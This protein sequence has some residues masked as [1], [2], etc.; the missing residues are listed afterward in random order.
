MKGPPSP[1]TCAMRAPRA[2]TR[3]RCWTLVV[4]GAICLAQLG[5]GFKRK[6]PKVWKLPCKNVAFERRVSEIL[7]VVDGSIEVGIPHDVYDRERVPGDRGRAYYLTEVGNFRARTTTITRPYWVRTHVTT[8]GEWTDVTGLDPPVV[9]EGCEGDRCPLVGLAFI[10]VLRFAN[11]VSERDGLEPCYDL[12]ACGELPEWP[13]YLHFR[14]RLCPGMPAPS[15]DCTG[16]RL[17]TGPEWEVASKAGRPGPFACSS[18]E[19][20]DVLL[21]LEVFMRGT[22]DYG[23]FCPIAH[24]WT[25]LLRRGDFPGSSAT[26]ELDLHA[27]PVGSLCP[28]RWGIYDA[29]GNVH[30][31]TW[32]FSFDEPDRLPAP[33]GSIDYAPA[34][35]G[36][37]HMRG[38]SFYFSYHTATSDSHR[39]LNNVPYPGAERA[40]G[41]RLVRTGTQEDVE[42][43]PELVRRPD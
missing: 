34:P 16:W 17:P 23:P 18:K 20:H 1:N 13:S 40:I 28:N 6:Q 2:R 21:G 12:A 5:C 11:A 8:V 33:D 3:T 22:L 43:Y 31:Y 24:G 32:A 9:D 19:V 38:G 39:T 14:E 42:A 26:D 4:L 29:T 36:L 10:D 41:F 25:D 27:L 37:P 7:V 35:G 15:L 30:Q